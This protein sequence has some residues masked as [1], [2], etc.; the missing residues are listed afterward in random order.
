MNNQ[1]YEVYNYNEF[2]S[3]LNTFTEPNTDVENFFKNF[4]FSE[5][6]NHNIEKGN[7]TFVFKNAIKEDNTKSK[8]INYLNKLSK[9]NLSKIA[10]GIREIV[11]QT[12]DELNE[13]VFQCIQKIKREN[14]L[15]RPL[16]AALCSDFLSLYFVTSDNDKIYFRKLLLS[17]VKKDY[18]NSISYDNEDWTKEKA[19][20]SMF[21]IGTLFNQKI[22]DSKIMTSII[23]DL[24]KNIIYK[25]NGSQEDYEKVE[26][27]LQQM[28][29]LISSI[30]FNDDS[31]YILGDLNI[32]LQKELDIYEEKKCISKKIRLV[33]K[34]TIYELNKIL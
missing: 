34:N 25:E 17:E 20:K 32:F 15:N 8:I 22:I 3:K 26:K 18:I 10:A 13:L 23:N 33:C 27:S 21:L 16:I 9:N 31:K 2:L 12:H 29:C 1:S 6:T 11:F 19:D 5:I 4:S 28:N 14:E 24:K 7:S 30:I